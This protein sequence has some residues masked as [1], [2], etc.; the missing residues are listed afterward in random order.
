MIKVGLIGGGGI[1]D[2]HIRGYRVYAETIAV[3]AVADVVYQTA[4]RRAAE[5]G[6]V[7]YTDFRQMILDADLDAV[8]VCLPHHLHGDVFVFLLGLL[9]ALNFLNEILEG[10]HFIPS[11]Y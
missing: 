2:A 8:G 1:A 11:L 3:T 4:S 10:V 9:L 5:L 7:G 6:A